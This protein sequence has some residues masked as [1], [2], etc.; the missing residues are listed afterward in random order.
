MTSRSKGVSWPWWV[1]PL[2]VGGSLAAFIAYSTWAVFQTGGYYADPYFSPFYTPCLAARCGEAA[3]FPLLGGWWTLSPALLV[4][5]HL[6]L[7]P[8][9]VLPGLLSGSP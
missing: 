4:A 9:G 5:G 7:L 3:T 2:V 8:Q 1:Q 6:L